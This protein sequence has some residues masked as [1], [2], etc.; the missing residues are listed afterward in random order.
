MQSCSRALQENTA[1][2][3]ETIVLVS[4]EHLLLISAE[5]GWC[6][7]VPGVSLQETLKSAS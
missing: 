2:E 6:D 4:A 7:Q 1:G 3:G 5:L